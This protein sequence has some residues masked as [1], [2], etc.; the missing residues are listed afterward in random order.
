VAYVFVVRWRGTSAAMTTLISCIVDVILGL[1]VLAIANII[2]EPVPLV[3]AVSW[4]L[5]LLLFCLARSHALGWASVGFIAGALLGTANHLFIHLT[6][7]ST[8]PPEGVYVHALGD[9]AL[10]V[11]CGVVALAAS[12]PRHSRFHGSA[13]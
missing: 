3:A 13:V 11:L 5:G 4:G 6:D 2:L 12:V 10:G 1:A 9:A 8:V 7:R